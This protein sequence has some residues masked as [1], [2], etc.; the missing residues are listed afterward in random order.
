[1]NI[2]I[3]VVILKEENCYIAKCLENNAVSQGKSIEIAL[4]NLKEAVSLYYEN[5][6]HEIIEKQFIFTTME[7]AI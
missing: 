6:T 7:V 5:E 1:M 2:K 4:T 3:N